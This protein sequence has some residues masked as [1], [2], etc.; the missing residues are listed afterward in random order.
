MKDVHLKRCGKFIKS[1]IGLFNLDLSDLTVYTELGSRNYAFTCVAAAMAN[2]KKVYAIS[3]TSRYGT[4]EDNLDNLEH[5]IHTL[6]NPQIRDKIEIVSEKNAEDLQAADIVT[7]SGFVRPIDEATVSMLKTT[8]VISLMYETWEFREADIELESCRS[9]GI[10]VLGTVEEC[11]PMDIMRYSGFLASKLLFECG[12]GV[13]KDKILIL[14]SG[15]LGNN[16]AHFMGVNGIDFSWISLDAHVRAENRQYLSEIEE[17]KRNLPKFD[18]I[19]VG[20]HYHSIELIGENGIIKTDIL[21]EKNSLVQIIH[22]CGNINVGDIKKYGLYVYPKHVMPFGYMS[23]SVD[24][25][26][27]KATIELNIAG[28]KV[29]EIMARNRLKYD[30]VKA[31]KESIKHS[32]VNDFSQNICYNNQNRDYSSS[33]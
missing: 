33:P 7:N 32:L 5:I 22:I 19:I 30:L 6:N 13:H 29:G 18:A 21:S 16:L 8:A 20:E 9:K 12:M 25:I 23:T 3:Q 17:V 2:A 4:F 14:G 10:L 24:C 31:Y 15:R 28:L 27:P 26:G 11:P 1:R